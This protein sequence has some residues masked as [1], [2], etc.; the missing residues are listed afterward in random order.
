V[1]WIH[2]TIAL[3][4]KHRHVYADISTLPARPTLLRAALTAA[5]EGRVAH[6]ILFGTDFP[7]TTIAS[8]ASA[9]RDV[10]ADQ[11]SSAAAVAARVVLKTCPLET[12]GL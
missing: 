11:P 1:P 9:L 5:G 4:R 10:I 2:E 7:V 6:K 12:L 8:T 3:V